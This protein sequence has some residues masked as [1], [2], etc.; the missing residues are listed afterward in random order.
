MTGFFNI[1]NSNYVYPDM[2]K[3]LPKNVKYNFFFILYVFRCF[4]YQVGSLIILRMR[5]NDFVSVF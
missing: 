4:T 2:A 3:T 5:P 1:L